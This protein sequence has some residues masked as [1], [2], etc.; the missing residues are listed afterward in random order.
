MMI[1]SWLRGGWGKKALRRLKISTQFGLFERGGWE[2]S[3]G[4]KKKGQ[5]LKCERR[6]KPI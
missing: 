6:I 1:C 4:V 2:R 3:P 5:A